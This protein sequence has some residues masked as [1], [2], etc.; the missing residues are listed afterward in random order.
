MNGFHKEWGRINEEGLI[1]VNFSIPFKNNYTCVV[2][3]YR[4]NKGHYDANIFIQAQEL[5]YI[6]ISG[7]NQASEY[8]CIG[9]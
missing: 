1:T 2:S 8:L 4:T 3:Q 5:T 7:Q 6:K 9:Y